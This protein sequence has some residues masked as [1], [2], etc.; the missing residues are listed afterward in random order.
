MSPSGDH[1]LPV[2][3]GLDWSIQNYTGHLGSCMVTKDLWGG[4]NM[5]Q[6]RGNLEV[7]YTNY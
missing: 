3:T 6:Q 5:G 2:E 4:G 1:K 7:G